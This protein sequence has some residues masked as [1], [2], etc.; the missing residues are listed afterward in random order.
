M[1]ALTSASGKDS[2]LHPPRLPE[3]AGK[4]EAQ[5]EFDW[6]GLI[7]AFALLTV[8]E[9][10]GELACTDQHVRNL[11]DDLKLLAF[12][13][14]LHDDAKRSEFRIVRASAENA[15]SFLTRA[16]RLSFAMDK[17][18]S[19]DSWLFKPFKPDLAWLKCVNIPTRSVLTVTECAKALRCSDTHIRQ[20]YAHRHLQAVDIAR[21]QT[22]AMHLRI[23]RLSLVTFVTRRLCRQ[24]NIEL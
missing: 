7:H 20:L 21:E 12:P 3:L 2:R 17:I 8:K 1:R 5:T 14:D 22:A 9:A 16:Q 19:V 10:R 4:E 15:F 23:T 24:N 18:R 13:I 11:V 6:S